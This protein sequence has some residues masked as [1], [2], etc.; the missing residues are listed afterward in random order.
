VSLI[1]CTVPKPKMCNVFQ[2]FA[3]VYCFILQSY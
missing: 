1:A 3:I 2:E